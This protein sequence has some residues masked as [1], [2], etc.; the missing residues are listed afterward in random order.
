MEKLSMLN[1]QDL[2]YVSLGKAAQESPKAFAFHGTTVP[3]E[4]TRARVHKSWQSWQAKPSF[5]QLSE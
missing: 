1:S 3:A 4:Q 5:S 2:V